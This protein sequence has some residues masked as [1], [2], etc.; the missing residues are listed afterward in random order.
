M[1]NILVGMEAVFNLAGL[2]AILAGTAAGILVGAMPGL[3]PSLGVALLI[4]VTYGL[5]PSVSLNML[6]ALYLAAEYGGSISAVLIGT[7][8]TA[9]ATATVMDGYP[10]NQKGEPGRALGASLVGSTI[11]G[12]V[13]GIALML[14]S[15]PLA[16][17]A[18]RFG[19]A[20]YCALGVFG[21]AIVASLSGKSL[22]K[23]LLAAAIG[24]A[25]TTV[26]VDPISGEPR[27]TFGYF[28]LYAGIPFLTALIG[29]FALTE[30]FSMVE[31]VGD[32]VKSDSRKVRGFLSARVI[33]R[34]IPTFI[35]G[36]VIGTVVGAV[37]G[38]G[39]NIAGWIAYDQ[40]KRWSGKGEQ[41]GEGCVEGV[42]A[43]ESANSASVGGAL[44]PLLTLG[45]PGS[46]TTAVLIGALI[47]HG[48][49]PGP[50][51]FEKNP[52][53][54]YGLFVGLVVA[55]VALFTL[56]RLAMPV[57]VRVIDVPKGILAVVVFALG[58]IGAYSIRNLMF[59]VWLAV[60]FGVC[61]FFLKK[62][63]FPMA[64]L[65]LGM[66]LGY[67]VESNY[68]RAMIMSQGSHSIFYEEPIS[69]AFLVLALLSFALPF[70]RAWRQHR[71]AKMAA[72]DSDRS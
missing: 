28:E 9:A 42:A 49:T 45:L 69:L 24:I 26:G 51:L 46:P 44:I 11:G 7:P 58:T 25:L 55:Y 21:L 35:R 52:E 39:A 31:Q 13:G 40:E 29:L 56:G 62:Y 60:G 66:V 34:L 64:P 3:G 19:P 53:V 47:L 41:F 59:D 67:M 48:L 17:L 20:E 8:G 14:I 37:P 54:I 32:R 36:S 38:A 33:L 22:L 27:F 16:A 18:L 72:I 70:V 30:V 57:W 61:G 50:E 43:P 6:V 23:G 2:A 65:V 1:E 63:R 15:E 71:E 10:L 68:R 12:I 4:P 5:S